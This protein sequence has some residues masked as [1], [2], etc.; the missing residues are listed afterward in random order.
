MIACE[1]CGTEYQPGSDS[2]LQALICPNCHSPRALPDPQPD[3]FSVFGLKPAFGLDETELARSYYAFSSALH[4][5]RFSAQGNEMITGRA[6]DWMSLINEAY[7]TLKKPA[8]R[9]AYLLELL[10]K[11]AP[12]SNP[13]LPAELS[14]EW[15]AI[16]DLLMDDLDA[17][18]RALKGF[19]QKIASENETIAQELR[20]LEQEWDQ[21]SETSVLSK[22]NDAMKRKAY[23]ASLAKNIERTKQTMTGANL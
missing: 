23:V 17:A 21:T 20:A 16:Q 2:P 9:R 5:D 15:F 4:P 13:P 8:D 12:K 19:S 18:M 14:E 1:F 6:G 11:D 3:F 22:M 7:Q 10:L